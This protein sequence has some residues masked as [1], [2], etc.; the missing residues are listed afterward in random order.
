M[1]RHLELV[2]VGEHADVAL[3]RVGVLIA[4][5]AQSAGAAVSAARQP[6][7]SPPAGAHSSSPLQNAPSS[8]SMSRAQLGASGASG[9][10]GAV[11]SLHATTRVGAPRLLDS[12]NPACRVARQGT[13]A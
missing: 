11:G 2:G 5:D 1:H 9:A 7:S 3:A 10:I 12:P 6:R 13:A 4:C 8:H